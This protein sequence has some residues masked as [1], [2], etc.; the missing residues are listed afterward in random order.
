MATLYVVGIGPGGKEHLTYKA[1][2]VLQ[3]CRVVVGYHFY[4]DLISELLEGKRVIATG[5][6]HELERCRQ[7]I[8]EVRSG[9]DTCLIS[10]GDPGLYGMAG[11]AL[12]VADDVAV[13]IVPGVSAAFCA[14]AEVGAPLMHDCCSISLS[15][16]LTPWDVIEHRLRHAA[17]A[18]FVIVLYN[19]KSRGRPHHLERAV[20]LLLR[21]KAPDTPVGLVKNAGRPGNARRLVTLATIAYEFVDMRT[22]VII[23]NRHTFIKD[24]SMITPRGYQW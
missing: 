3:R 12:E 16:L 15:D 19:P 14:A 20:A 8:A 11:P 21:D 17:Q 9:H 23:G 13:E 4:L 22:V 6:R 5:M 18:D 1:L 2:E 7:A 24:G 10:T